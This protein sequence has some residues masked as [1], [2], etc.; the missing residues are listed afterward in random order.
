VLHLYNAVK[1]QVSSWTDTETMINMYGESHI[2]KGGAP[3]KLKEQLKRFMLAAGVPTF[4]T[5][6]KHRRSQETAGAVFFVKQPL[7]D[8]IH[9]RYSV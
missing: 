4:P 7:L 9:K 2:F 1:T 3:T 6:Y 5:R 8:V